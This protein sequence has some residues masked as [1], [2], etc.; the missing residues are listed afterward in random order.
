MTPGRAA[1]GRAPGRPARAP[2]RAA[3]DAPLRA[4][5]ARPAPG[6]PRDVPAQ[7]RDRRPARRRGSGGGQIREPRSLV[8]LCDISG[9]MERHSRLLLRFVQALSAA[10]EV[11]TESFVFG[12][13]LTRVTRLLRDRDRDR[14]L[15]RVADVGQRLGRRD[16]D[17]R[18]VPDV[19]PAVGA[20]VAADV[21]RRHRRLRRLGPRRPG[22]RRHRDRPPAAQLPSPDLAQPAGGHAR[23]PAAGRRD[24]RRLSRTSTTSCRPGPSPTSSASARSS[25]ASGPADTR[26]GSEAA[27]HAALPGVHAD[28]RGVRASCAP[29]DR[30]SAA[31]DRSD[32]TSTEGR[33]R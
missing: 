33:L 14:A 31:H 22:A 7:P 23:L 28:R 11:R 20:A 29:P 9:S 25:A 8:V 26:R 2:P 4:A 16:A 5:L 27:A 6:A 32:P 18:V 30:S 1:R 21:G 15:A 3:P 19:Q 17:R 10:S 24:A 13:R 12:T